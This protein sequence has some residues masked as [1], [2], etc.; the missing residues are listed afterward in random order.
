MI[1]QLP[2]KS[3]NNES[4]TMLTTIYLLLTLIR[5]R[6]GRQVNLPRGN[7]NENGRLEK[8]ESEKLA[9]TR[10]IKLFSEIS[11][12]H[13]SPDPISLFQRMRGWRARLATL[14][15]TGTGQAVDRQLAKRLVPNLYTL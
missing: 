5:I 11:L 8:C 15:Q 9:I 1:P 10:D 3:H 6:D 13:E 7:F 12:W 14:S 2:A 4:T